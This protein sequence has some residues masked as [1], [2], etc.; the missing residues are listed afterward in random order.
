VIQQVKGSPLIELHLRG[1]SAIER[2]VKHSK[3][4]PAAVRE[5]S[6]AAG[7]MPPQDAIII[8]RA[9]TQL[10]RE[11]LHEPNSNN[12]PDMAT[13]WLREIQPGLPDAEMKAYVE[14][15]QP[16]IERLIAGKIEIE[17]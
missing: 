6:G 5:A 10:L 4:Q 9:E 15:L 16:I 13:R 17:A 14:R 11:N 2:L 1:A 7:D 8:D 12:T 3:L